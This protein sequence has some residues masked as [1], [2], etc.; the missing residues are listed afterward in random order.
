MIIEIFEEAK[1]SGS[2]RIGSGLFI[3]SGESL[4]EQAK[5][6][7]NVTPDEILSNCNCTHDCDCALSE[8]NQDLYD[9][10]YDQEKAAF[11]FGEETFYV[12]TDDGTNPVE[13]TKETFFDHFELSDIE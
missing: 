10:F 3:T 12:T 9:T 7:E 2:A 11:D 6:W 4:T 8:E 5:H 13:I 1:N